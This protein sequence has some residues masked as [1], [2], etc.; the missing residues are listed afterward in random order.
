MYVCLCKGITDTQI[1]EAASQ[2]ATSLSHVRRQLGL[3]TCCG[4][5]AATTKEILNEHRNSEMA[6]SGLYYSVA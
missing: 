1:R 3:A 6:N 5:C 4:K 2:G